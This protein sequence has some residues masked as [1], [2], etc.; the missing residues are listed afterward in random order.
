MVA[1]ET[2]GDLLAGLLLKSMRQRWPDLVAAGIGGPRM[3]EQG[4]EAWWPSDQLAVR[5]YLEVLP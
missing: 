3:V 5:G 1:G 4:F 2:S